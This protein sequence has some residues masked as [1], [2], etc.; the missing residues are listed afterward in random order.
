[1]TEKQKEKL[2]AEIERTEQLKEYERTYEK[3]NFICG[4]DEAGRGPLAGPVVAGAV[5]LP[6][7]CDILYIND[8]KKLSE[9]KRNE[10]Y[11]I[12]TKKAVS[13]AVG[14]VEQDVIDEIN[15]LQ[16][17]YEAMRQAINKLTVQPDI[18]LN[19]AVTI[20][21]VKIKQ[22]PIIKGDA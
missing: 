12:I 20:P 16:A 5:I 15:I 14:I 7:D 11:E 9:K 13:W 6:K 22:V 4:I 19:D 8:S 1:M 18:L 17:T 3:Y 10:L 2:K 21:D